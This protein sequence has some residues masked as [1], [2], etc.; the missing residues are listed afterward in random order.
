MGTQPVPVD[1]IPVIPPPPPTPPVPPALPN[2]A[3]CVPTMDIA[4]SRWSFKTGS[5][6][7]CGTDTAIATSDRNAFTFFGPS[8]CAADKG[9]ILTA[10][11]STLGLQAD[12]FDF[13]V[14]YASF[15]YYH[16]SQPYI[17]MSRTNESFVVT[18]T[19]YIHATRIA[20]GTFSGTAY[21]VDGRAVNITDGKFKV[22][23]P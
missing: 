8:A 10:Y 11:L 22:A 3:V 5:S 14:P 4:L 17:L 9:M 19:S 12:I 7:I 18:I 1:T 23:L 6:L 16:T 21:Q 15:F 20:T 2:C 13:R